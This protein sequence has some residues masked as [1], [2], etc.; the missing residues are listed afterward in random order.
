MVVEEPGLSGEKRI[1]HKEQTVRPTLEQDHT[2]FRALAGE[3]RLGYD[4]QE[5]VGQI[6]VHGLSVRHGDL[7]WDWAR[8]AN[9]ATGPV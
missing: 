4:Q 3:I 1:I 7:P 5:G 6:E 8:A 2:R 9:A